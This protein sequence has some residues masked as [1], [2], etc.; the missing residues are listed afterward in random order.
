[1]KTISATKGQQT[2]D[3]IIK[4]AA[5]LFHKQ[6]Y[7]NTGLQQI[8]QSAG[9]TKGAFYFHFKDKKSLGINVSERYI[10]AFK[11]YFGDVFNS[12]NKSAAER[13]YQF[14]LSARAMFEKEYG[15]IGCP[16]G[17]LSLELATEDKEIQMALTRGFE[18]FTRAFESLLE[19]GEKDGSITLTQPK[20]AFASFM[21]NSWEGAVLRMKATQS[22]SPLDNWY[23]T[24][25]SLLG[26]ETIT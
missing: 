21:V 18:L 15:L 2:R 7:H 14:H 19:D 17:N 8:L 22:L 3:H 13:I 1:M 25:T 10:H 23:A 11:V 20:T 6:G 26:I 4:V 24:L 12:R 9:V 5:E 16:M